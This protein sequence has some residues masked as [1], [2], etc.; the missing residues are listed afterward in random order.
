MSSAKDLTIKF[1]DVKPTNLSFTK[2]E[3]ND[4]SNG[5]KVGYVRYIN[6]NTDAEVT[7]FI[8]LPWITLSSYGIPRDDKWHTTDASRANIKLPLDDSNSEVNEFIKLLKEIDNHLGSDE[9]KQQLFGSASAKYMYAGLFRLPQLPDEDDDNKK[10]KTNLD[11]M[12]P[13]FR[14]KINTTFPDCNIL[15]QVYKS[16]MEDNKRVRTLI[17]DITTIDDLARHVTFLSKVRLIIRPVKIWA[18]TKTT[19]TNPYLSYGLTFKVMKIEYEPSDKKGSYVSKEFLEGDAFVDGSDDESS[20][21]VMRMNL[22]DDE[23]SK[24]VVKQTK[25]PVKVEVDDSDDEPVQTKKTVKV[26][27][28]SDDSDDE[29]VKPVKPV[30]TK[31]PIKVEVESDD[32]DDEPVK[33]VK[34]VQTKKPIKVEVESDDS[35]DEPV[36]PVK[37]TKKPIKVEVESDDSD[38]EPVKPTKVVKG[39]GKK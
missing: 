35:D 29:P 24:P 28:E 8:Q 25:K 37:Q 10:P 9:M 26:E 20:K 21:P 2:P 23:T 30:Q 31:K 4:R 39:K 15:T 1:S 11:D 22:S 17:T 38:D 33:P 12:K 16:T 19:P 13:Y 6:P 27:V 18:T 32:S 3:V 36:K 5:Q 7:P 34:P 14:A